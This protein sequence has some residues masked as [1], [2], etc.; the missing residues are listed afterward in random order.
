LVGATDQL[1]PETRA[2]SVRRGDPEAREPGNSL[3]LIVE[4]SPGVVPAVPENAGFVLC[5][6]LPLTGRLNVTAGRTVPT[7]QDLWA[8]ARSSVPETLV[9]RT[10]KPCAPPTSA[11]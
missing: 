11:R 9:A 7:V 6:V 8:W 1:P 10:S 5:V 4:E 2:T 3:T